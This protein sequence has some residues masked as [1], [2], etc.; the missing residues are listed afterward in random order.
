MS[1]EK[2][3]LCVLSWNV[4]RVSGGLGMLVQHIS[5]LEEWDAILLQ[6]LSFKDELLS[7]EE[8]EASLGGHKL[9]A[10]VECPWDTAI[11]IHCR[12][13]CAIRWFA[14]VTVCIVGW[15]ESRGG[16]YFLLCAPAKLGE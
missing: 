16:V 1:R 5:E 9:V 4:Q 7:L 3:E 11:I 14:S 12:W 13:M 10:N 15:V 2:W 8:L 6:E